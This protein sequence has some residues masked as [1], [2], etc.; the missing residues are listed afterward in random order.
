MS[1]HFVVCMKQVPMVSELP[2]DSRTGRLQRELA[3]GMMNPACKFAL[4]AAIQLKERHGARI[5]AL[6]MGPAM[7]EEILR[8]AM[9]MGADRGI[10]LTDPNMAGADTMITSFTL[11]RAIT[12]ECPD[13]DL[14]LCGCQTSDSETAQVGPQLAEELDVAGVAYVEKLELQ[15]RTVRLE[16][17]TDDFLE[18]IEMD[19]PGV[20]TIAT[21]HYSPRYASLGG[22]QDAFDRDTI[23]IMDAK[24]LGLTPE[25]IGRRASPTRILD[26]YS[27][28]AHKEN[29]VMRG[30]AKK[31]VED[32]F[33]QFGDQ[34]GAAIGKDLKSHD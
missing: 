4:E 18:T 19:L 10:L 8:E 32:L 9:A 33:D 25:Q 14:V 34:I 1:Y 12:R 5:T 2:W 27:P 21:Q 6:T 15:N 26:V 24:G 13:F 30:S 16:R 11:S 31:V 28:V 20:I 23:Q 3:D 29:I 17:E 22:L 7:A